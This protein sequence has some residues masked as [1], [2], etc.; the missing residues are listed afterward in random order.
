MVGR[1]FAASQGVTLYFD[2]V[3]VATTTTDGAGTFAISSFVMPASSAGV[4]VLRAQDASANSFSVNMNAVSSF[5]I[6]PTVGPVA[7]AV[8]VTG[9]GFRASEAI[10]LK[11]DAAAATTTPV[12]SDAKGSFTATFNVPAAASGTHAVTAADTVN[13]STKSFTVSSTAASTPA[14]GFVGTKIT[15]TGSGYLATAA[16]NVLFDSAPVK[17]GTSD[18][19]GNFN[20]SFDAPAKAAGAYKIR[21]TDGT[22]SKDLDFT[23]TTSAAISP[24]TSNAAPGNVGQAIT[25]SGVGFKPGASLAVTYD[26]KPIATGTVGADA[27]F[28]V[29]F[30]AP[31]SKTGQHTITASDGLN[32]L[33]L[34][35]FMEST[36]PPAPAQT[37]PIAGSRLKG[38]GVFTWSPVT[39]P[40]GVTYVFQIATDSAFT[41]SSILLEKT[42]LTSSQYTLTKEEKLKPT[43]KD[44]PDYWRVRAIDGASNEGAWSNARSLIVGSPFPAWAVWTLVGLGAVIVLLFVFWLGRRTSAKPPTTRLDEHGQPL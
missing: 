10:A 30:N 40:S 37:E 6:T 20:I 31:A 2:E 15:V 5:A 3:A 35:F 42:D 43:K 4:H 13:T 16:V 14:S 1:G 33:A 25:V 38:D 18:A 9:T 24:V 34:P 28:S 19:N 32:N 36:P 27:K 26:N 41:T 17:A 44:L 29:T 39:D 7:T 11:F 22:N 8:T 21:V 23:V 12:T